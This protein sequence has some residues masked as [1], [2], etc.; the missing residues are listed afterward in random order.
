MGQMW[1]FV[2]ACLPWVILLAVYASVGASFGAIVDNWCRYHSPMSEEGRDKLWIAVLITWPVLVPILVCYVGFRGIHPQTRRMKEAETRELERERHLRAKRDE[3][4]EE[5]YE[6]SI[7]TAT[8]LRNALA[9]NSDLTEE[10]LATIHRL[11]R[12]V[13]VYQQITSGS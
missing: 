12:L 3:A 11:Q 10:E 2:T 4:K 7:Q 8:T 9:T 6:L 5:F 1:D 13:P